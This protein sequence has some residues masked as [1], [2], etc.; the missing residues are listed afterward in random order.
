MPMIAFLIVFPF[1]AALALAFMKR[2]GKGRKYFIFACC[3]AIVAGVVWFAGDALLGSG[4]LSLLPE[5]KTVDMGILAAEIGL[6]G[7]IVFYGFKFRKYYVALLSVAQTGL[8]AWLELTGKNEIAGNRIF[9]DKLTV[10]MVLI[11]G[12][13]G[14]LICVYA[15]G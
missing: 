4:D 5:A 9:S 3:I 14:C 6:M 7:L 8:I 1:L 15:V 2:H 12:V 10:I 11:V 13:V